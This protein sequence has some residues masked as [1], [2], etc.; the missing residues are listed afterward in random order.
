MMIQNKWVGGVL[1]TA[2]FAFAGCGDGEECSVTSL[3]DGSAE[4]VCADGTRTTIPRPASGTPPDTCK[5][6]D[7]DGDRFVRCGAVEYPIGSTTPLC[8]T[9]WYDGD[10]A[11]PSMTPL[12]EA[13]FQAFEASQCVN[14]RGSVTIGGIRPGPSDSNGDVGEIVPLV[15]IPASLLALE[16]IAGSLRFSG[17]EFAAPVVFPSL[18]S[19]RPSSNDWWYGSGVEFSMVKG[20]SEFDFPELLSAGGIRIYSSGRGEGGG[21]GEELPPLQRISAPKLV[22]SGSTETRFSLSAYGAYAQHLA[23]PALTAAEIDM[24]AWQFTVD[25]LDVRSL[26]EGQVWFSLDQDST[27]LIPSAVPEGYPGVEG[28]INLRS[29]A[30]VDPSSILAVWPNVNVSLEFEP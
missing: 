14:I 3:A 7:K 2:M 24:G 25:Y 19:I 18:K 29:G 13:G 15:G 4:I 1:A 30:G 22:G 27:F 17:A 12:E 11:Y 9:G 28:T 20:V 16:S 6:I 8:P 26:V 10:V 23:L 5:L 21:T